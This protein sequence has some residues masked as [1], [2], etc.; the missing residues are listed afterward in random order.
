MDT[1]LITSIIR[2]YINK[3]FEDARSIKKIASLIDDVIIPMVKQSR[4][5]CSVLSLYRSSANTTCYVNFAQ[6]LSI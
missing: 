4:S 2:T 5:A 3:R 1:L 6:F